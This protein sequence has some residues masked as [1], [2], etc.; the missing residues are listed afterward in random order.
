MFAW[1]WKWNIKVI[2]INF[3]EQSDDS[4]EGGKSQLN[5]FTGCV[6]EEAEEMEKHRVYL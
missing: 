4:D 3:Q 6:D 5:K 2:S 1:L